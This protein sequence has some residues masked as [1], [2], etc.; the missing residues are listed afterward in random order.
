[1]KTYFL[2]KKTFFCDFFLCSIIFF[3]IFS[4]SENEIIDDNFMRNNE[5]K[6]RSIQTPYLDW[7]NA[8]WMPTPPNQAK[9]PSPWTGQ[10]SLVS[11]LGIDVLND[12]MAC[13]GWEL[14]YNSFDA[15]LPQLINPYFILYN[16][17]RGL[18][19]IYLFITTQFVTTSS[20]IQDGLSVV[21]TKPTSILNFLGQD[22]VDATVKKDL[23]LQIQS[24]PYD[25]S[26][27]LASNKW[28]MLQYELAYDPELANIP[29]NQ[30]Q[31]SWFLNYCD[32][33]SIS[34]SGN[35]SGTLSGTIGT[36]ESYNNNVVKSL[37]NAG[38]GVGT[39]VLAGIGKS[40]I[41]HNAIGSDGS[42]KLGL[43]KEIFQS[44]SKGV[45]S[46]LSSA[47]GGLP[48]LGM[49]ILSAVFGGGSNSTPVS[50]TMKTKIELTGKIS[51]YG[52]FPSMPI[53]FWM[54]GTLISPNAVGYLPNYN[55]VLGV[56]NFNGK[57]EIQLCYSEFCRKIPDEPFDPDY[58][59]EYSEIK[60]Y[61]ES[62]TIDFSSY[63]IINPKVSAIADINILNQEL[64]FVTGVESTK[65]GQDDIPMG[66]SK[67]NPVMFVIDNRG[68][69][70]R[71]PMGI[72]IN[73]NSVTVGVR[74]TIR[75][76]PKNNAPSSTI[77]KTFLLK[78]K[79]SYSYD[80]V[81]G[82]W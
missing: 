70:T 71:Y 1:M 13:D 25:N 34:I 77:I 35:Q 56:L 5:L 31:L 45:T 47:V 12:R 29:Y 65:I 21:S 58:T 39:V 4:C 40:F 23:Y 76:S 72:Y 68:G 8:D 30:I 24:A 57:P 48:S 19:R 69:A 36:S 80:E 79:W 55:N 63:L 75:V 46:G 73:M 49:S 22:A 59:T 64:V 74:M 3:F 43:S 42:N 17:Y 18:M 67:D 33:H 14:L 54:P 27:P 41:D 20:Y 44:I 51:S 52:S 15:N 10:G 61:P 2:S 62:K 26:C 32:V 16:K 11:T 6:T 9:I 66:C 60:V 82:W 53:S 37:T 81:Y 38:K 7:E 28:H 78:P 50:L